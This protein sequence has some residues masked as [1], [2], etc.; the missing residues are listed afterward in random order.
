MLYLPMCSPIA[1]VNPSMDKTISLV[2]E[3]GF[4]SVGQ[5]ASEDLG[6]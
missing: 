6:L 5:L 3:S 1:D 4:V 2:F